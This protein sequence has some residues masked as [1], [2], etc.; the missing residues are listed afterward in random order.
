MTQTILGAN[1]QIGRELALSLHRHYTSQIRLVS[2]NPQK[3]N[4]SD[5]LFKANLLSPEQTLAAVAGSSVAYLTVG[6]P[7]D[8]KLWVQQWPV[9]MRNAITACEHH[10]TKLVF[11][12]NTYMYPQT[13][14]V[15]TEE[16]SFEPHGLKGRVRAE[17]AQQLL[18]AMKQGR[19]EALICRAPEFYGPGLTQSITNATIINNLKVGKK[20]RVFLR[21]DTLRT[22]IYT[23]D[24]SRAMALLGNTLEAYGQTW[25]LPCDDDRLTYKEFVSLAAQT[26]GVAANYTVL[27]E[28]QLKFAGLFNTQ[29]RDAAELLPR[30]KVDNLFDSSKFKRQFPTFEVTPI[31]A[32]LGAI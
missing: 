29:I 20:A 28:W 30:Y 11:F 4:A 15:Q 24:A 32:G 18:Q 27:K 9:M 5:E 16:T 13:A 14:A 25:H 17:I 3:I 31:K 2:R 1:G 10:N 12:D 26:F 19:V 23:P 22:L 21:D 8:T 6:L 7:M